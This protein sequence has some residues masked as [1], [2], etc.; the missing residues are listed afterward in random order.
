MISRFNYT[1]RKRIRHKM[2]D[3]VV[4]EGPPRTFDA[5]FNFEG[6]ILES[7]AKIYV[8]AMSGGSPTVMRFDFGSVA[9]PQAPT[10]TRLSDLAGE[11][12]HFTVKVVDE[13]ED[14]GKLLGLC[15]NIR[16]KRPDEGGESG[17]MSILPVNPTGELGETVWRL[18]FANGRPWLDVNNRIPGI[19]QIARD[20]RQF[21]ALVY[22]EVVRQVLY[23]VLVREG[24]FEVQNDDNDWRDQW[25]RFALHWH[26]DKAAPPNV[27]DS[28]NLTDE[29]IEQTE[30]WIDEAVRRFSD[31][32]GVRAEYETAI[33]REPD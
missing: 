19:M 8:E 12:V 30:G 2:I 25:L 23:R 31:L 4:I 27:Q 11:A 9:A 3:I 18:N 1:D 13:R 21:F 32:K 28:Q 10:N 15:E 24:Y 26:P 5:T 7:D 20:D 33:N 22:P 17:Q 6:I 14:V 29:E 16:P